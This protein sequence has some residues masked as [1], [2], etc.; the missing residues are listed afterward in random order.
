MLDMASELLRDELL[1]GLD[2]VPH[3][4]IAP[5]V[6]SPTDLRP[7]QSFLDDFRNELHAVRD[8]LFERLQADLGLRHRFFQKKHGHLSSSSTTST[9]SFRPRQSKVNEY[10]LTVQRFIRLIGV[11]IYWTS[12][13]PPRRKELLGLSWCNHETA[14]NIY[15]SN[16][17]MVFITGYHKSSWRIGYRPIARFLAPAVGDLLVRYLILV[18][19]FVRFLSRCMQS[20]CQNHFLFSEGDKVWSPDRFGNLLKR[21]SA[22]VNTQINNCC[23]SN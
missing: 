17:M 4:S 22:L 20:S 7:G 16:G 18:P 8:W 2:D 12:G 21:Q 11:L 6:D 15:I 9:Q 14:R 19:A 13:L 3:Y 1:F 23:S 5:L 10:L